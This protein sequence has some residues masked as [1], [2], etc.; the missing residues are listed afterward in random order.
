MRLLHDFRHI[1]QEGKN[2]LSTLVADIRIACR[3]MRRSPAFTAVVVGTL[4]LGIGA[5]AAMFTLVHAAL[6][7]PLPYAEPERLVMAR[8]TTGGQVQS[9]NSTPDFYDYREQ[10]TSFESLMA[11]Q[12]ISLRATVLD[13]AE[14]V[15]ATRVS[16]D[17][18]SGMGVRPVAGRSFVASDGRADAPRVVV[19]GEQMARRR[20]GTSQSAIGRTI[21]LSGMGRS[22][23]S[24][25][26]VGVLPSTYRF[27]SDA[28]VWMPMRQGENDAP[29]TRNQHRWLLVGRLK[30]GVNLH[31]AQLEVDGIARRLQ[32]QYPASNKGKGLQLDPLQ[33][34]LSASGR[35]RLLVLTGAVGLVLLIACANVTGLLLARG[36][37]RRSELAVRAALG[38][39][40]GRLVAQLLTEC[41][42]L[43]TFGGLLGV[44]LAT[45]LQRLFSVAS[46]LANQ[47]GAPHGTSLPVLLFA[48]ALSLATGLLFGIVPVVTASATCFAADLVPGARSTGS[49]GGTRLRSVLVAGQVAV[50]LTLLVSAAL[51]IRS[52]V[53]L[54]TTSLGLDTAQLVAG[55]IE[56]PRTS[57]GGRLPFYQELRDE[58][59]AL[60]GVTSVGFISHLPIRDA[61]DDLPMWVTGQRA[62]DASRER[63]ANMRLALPGYFTT[64]GI[65]LVAGRDISDGDTAQSARVLVINQRMAATLFPGVNPLG[66][67]VTVTSQP[68]PIDFEVVGVVG[69]ARIDGVALPPPMTMYAP[70]DQF[71]ETNT[72]MSFVVRTALMPAAL[73]EPLGRLVAARNPNVPVDKLVTMEELIGASLVLQRATTMLLGTFSGVALLLAAVGLYGILAY[74]VAQRSREFGVRMALGATPKALVTQVL[75]R[76]ALMVLPGLAVGL[77]ASRAASGLI[78]QFLYQLPPTDTLAYGGA[79]ICLTGVALAASAV[80]AY[81]AARVNP[82]QALRGD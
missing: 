10:A 59:A 35:P 34:V 6:L 64:I 70:V 7:K 37:S 48:I 15:M 18:F 51:L 2:V 31:S 42:L 66:Q 9:L 54:N 25:T 4:A 24:A 81:R 57:A 29:Q 58:L 20:Y 53:Q 79:I 71:W 5:N 22:D 38:A 44:V 36:T 69:D 55:T 28:D 63:T 56:L 49:R 47:A 41:G 67:H 33:A 72:Q 76:G 39:T 30:R 61:F 21:P 14:R 68:Q 23:F 16:A 65:P 11:T 40:R 12:G 46:G 75:A 50:S 13:P 45:W 78:A 80:P 8:R 27:I 1:R 82:V 52:F 17:F 19:I 74:Q 60:P 26:V 62:A 3:S 43:A 73:T 77:A 32:Q